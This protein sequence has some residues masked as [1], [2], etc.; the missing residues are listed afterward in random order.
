MN[1]ILIDT[2][3]LIY[4]L[5]ET[6]N[7]YE[8]TVGLL[9]NDEFNLFVTTKNISEFFAVC[10]KLKIDFSKTFG[11]YK[12]LKENVTILKPTDQSLTHFENLIQKYHPKGNLVYD[13]EIVSIMLANNMTTIA[14]ANIEDFKN[15]EEIYLLE[16]K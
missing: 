9:Q 6:S 13:I 12:D 15:V 11:F 14:T 16:I 2:N 7:F 3:L 8:Q 10:S 1:N 5:D 4:A